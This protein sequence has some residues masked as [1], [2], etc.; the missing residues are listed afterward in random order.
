M[1]EWRCYSA[2]TVFD[3]KIV[4]TGGYKDYKICKS[5]EAYNYHE[6]EW[7]HLQNVLVY[8][9]KP[10]LI[11]ICIGKFIFTNNYYIY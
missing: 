8:R 6:N 7:T 9:Y 3:G 1:T 11:F 10:F 2:C 4:L 5:V